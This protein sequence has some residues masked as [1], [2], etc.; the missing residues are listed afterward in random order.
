MHGSIIKVA[1]LR[2]QPPGPQA[3]PTIYETLCI[4]R[5]PCHPQNTFLL[6]Q[7]IGENWVAESYVEICVILSLIGSSVRSVSLGRG[8]LT[9]AMTFE[10]GALRQEVEATQEFIRASAAVAPVDSATVEYHMTTLKG[11]ILGGTG[12]YSLTNSK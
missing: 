7:A 10:L 11:K 2:S 9:G 5:Y 6:Y 12:R 8:A 3:S 1:A 4:L